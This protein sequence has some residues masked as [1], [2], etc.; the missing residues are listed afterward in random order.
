MYNI[1]SRVSMADRR[2]L[3]ASSARGRG[4]LDARRRPDR[5]GA[6]WAESTRARAR[7]F[8]QGPR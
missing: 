4:A 8:A 3:P 7:A 5:G 6:V 1:I 2:R